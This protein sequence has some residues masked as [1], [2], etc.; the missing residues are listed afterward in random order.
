MKGTKKMKTIITT[1]IR[2]KINM[3]NSKIINVS[4]I[5][6]NIF[7]LLPIIAIFFLMLF[8]PEYNKDSVLTGVM[9]IILIPTLFYNGYFWILRVAGANLY[10]L[11]AIFLVQL[12]I[13]IFLVGMGGESSYNMQEVAKIAKEIF[14]VFSIPAIFFE[15][16]FLLIY[17]NERNVKSTNFTLILIALTIFYAFFG[18]KFI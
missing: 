12:I 3:N 15:I 11:F 17:R 6:L 18:F 9:V 4:Q 5:V 13:S 7:G 1:G 10:F 16:V 2:I 8:K 14:M